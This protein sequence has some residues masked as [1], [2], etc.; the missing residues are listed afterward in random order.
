VLTC[1]MRVLGRGFIDFAIV[2][3]LGVLLLAALLNVTGC[4]VQPVDSGTGQDIGGP[5]SRLDAP[6]TSPSGAPVV[7]KNTDKV[8]TDRVVEDGGAGLQAVLVEFGPWGVIGAAAIGV[9]VQQY[10]G[11]KKKQK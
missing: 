5:V 1:R 11:R 7:L 10:R 4:Q 6:T 3:V 9:A 2:V 8:D